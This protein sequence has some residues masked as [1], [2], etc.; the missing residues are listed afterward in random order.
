M[1]YIMDMHEELAPVDF[2]VFPVVRCPL[3]ICRGS[4]R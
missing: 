3:N 2:E 4:G 1:I